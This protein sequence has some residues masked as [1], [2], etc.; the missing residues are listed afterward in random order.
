MTT[1]YAL[2]RHGD[3]SGKVKI[4]ASRRSGVSKDM[5][6]EEERRT[7]KDFICHLVV[8]RSISLCQLSTV[9]MS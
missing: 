1:V 2:G 3:W 7:G 8:V 4:R 5:E 9:Y 6:L